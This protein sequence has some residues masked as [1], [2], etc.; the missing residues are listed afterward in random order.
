MRRRSHGKRTSKLYTETISA[1][2][3]Y[4]C[5]IM[6]IDPTAYKIPCIVRG[7]LFNVELLL[8]LNKASYVHHVTAALRSAQCEEIQN[9]ST[10]FFASALRSAQCEEIQNL[11]TLLILVAVDSSRTNVSAHQLLNSSSFQQRKVQVTE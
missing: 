2:K 7:L 8:L 3:T 9:L 11:S 1:G 10:L 4:R 6:M 5:D